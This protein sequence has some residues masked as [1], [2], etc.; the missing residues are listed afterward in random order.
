[1]TSPQKQN[2]QKI[3]SEKSVVIALKKKSNTLDFNW[4]I[5]QMIIEE[6]EKVQKTS[7]QNNEKEVNKVSI[8]DREQRLNRF[9]TFKKKPLLSISNL[10]SIT[11]HIKR[12]K[13]SEKLSRRDV[14]YYDLYA[15]KEPP[16]DYERMREEGFIHTKVDAQI[17]ELYGDLAFQDFNNIFKNHG[18]IISKQ[19]G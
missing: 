11:K 18:D 14:Q 1:M 6:E 19:Y 17:K 2:S 16:E 4:Y 12:N 5:N 13:L 3:Q 15:L 9:H 7:E 10:Q 8:I